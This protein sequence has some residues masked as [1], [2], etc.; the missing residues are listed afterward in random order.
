MG[1]KVGGQMVSIWMG[2]Y[3]TVFVSDPAL[4]KEIWY[5]NFANF[6]NRR[7][8]PI[9]RLLSG[10]YKNLLS[11]DYGFW[12][13]LRAMVAN[14]FTK[15]KLRSMS[16]IIDEQAQ[17]FVKKMYEY[18]ATG[19]PFTPTMFCKKY[20]MNIILMIVFSKHIPYE[21]DVS[22]GILGSLVEPID[23]ILRECSQGRVLFS[24]N[25]IAPLIE[26]FF[27]HKVLK[28][29]K[30]IKSY[31]SAMY[32]EKL[33]DLDRNNPKD[34]FEDIIVER[35]DMDTIAHVAMDLLL[36]GTD[37][38]ES[39]I[40]WIILYMCNYPELQEK[41]H[42]ELS[43]IIGKGNFAV[44]ADRPRT[45]YM[46]AFIKE[47]L[48]IKPLAPFGL[49]RTNAE[50]CTI[51]GF[52]LPKNTQM[53]INIYAIHHDEKYWK[54]PEVFLPERFLDEKSINPDAWIP[55]GVG[56]RNCVG[57]NL[58][59]DEIYVACA[60]IFLNFKME[61][62]TGKPID[63]EEVFGLTIHPKKYSVNLIKR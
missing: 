45:P 46:T 5:K 9:G 15:T 11:S 44:V 16:K 51:G 7:H 58:A 52:F 55:F 29:M 53:L 30:K 10:G 23:D 34:L 41:V 14:T 36:A 20:S 62:S 2:D 3:Y 4:V 12:K 32:E 56:Q 35:D 63:D 49:N 38:S 50:E 31:V 57:M 6:A 48:R 61:S 17:L 59:M 40:E 28:S 37:T 24:L 26:H 27:S 18:H 43:E 54:D 22:E 47:V 1:R 21:E 13:P 39:T 25:A 60:N 8:Q 19:Q 33:V 42:A